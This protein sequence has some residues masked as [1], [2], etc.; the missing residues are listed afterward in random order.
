V[1]QIYLGGMFFP[2]AKISVNAMITSDHAPIFLNLLRKHGTEGNKPRFQYEA[3]WALKERGK[4]MLN[5]VWT[6]TKAH[7][8]NWNRLGVKLGRCVFALMS[9]RKDTKGHLKGEISKL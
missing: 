8:G 9:W 7:G 1:S 2:D 5:H 6:Q 4:E 3:S